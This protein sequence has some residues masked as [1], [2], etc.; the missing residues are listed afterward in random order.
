[1]V[2]A[3]DKPDMTQVAESTKAKKRSSLYDDQYATRHNPFVYFHSIIDNEPNCEANV[4][5]LSSLDDDLKTADATPNFVF[6]TPNLCND[7]HDSP[8]KDGEPGGLASVNNFLKQL[9]PQILKAPAFKQD[10]LLIVTFDEADIDMDGPD[11]NGNYWSDNAEAFEA[12][13]D[14]KP[15]PNYK[16]GETIGGTTPSRGPGIMGPGGG[17]VGA[18]L[19]SPFILPETSS[20]VLYNHYSMLRTLEDVFGLQHHLGYAGRPELQRFGPD[21][22]TRPGG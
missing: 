14:E 10:G 20:A 1:V 3:L 13:C 4:V 22:F 6:I 5:P 18:V 17:R 11:R 8:C 21:V 12:C 16:E 7:G 2:T 15:G 19:L 9:V